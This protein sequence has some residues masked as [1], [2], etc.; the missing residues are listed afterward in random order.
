MSAE[1]GADASIKSL[2]RASGRAYGGRGQRRP[3][4]VRT[5]GA[6][7]TAVCTEEFDTVGSPKAERVTIEALLV[8]PQTR[9]LH[10]CRVRVSQD[11]IVLCR[12]AGPP[13][14][15]HD[16]RTRPMESEPVLVSWRSLRGFSA[17]ESYMTPAG[18]RLQVLE[19]DADEG[20][21]T[22]LAAAPEVSEL[23]GMVGR[24]SGHWRLAR[25]PLGLVLGGR[26][27]RASRQVA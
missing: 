21:L 2:S 17:D 1:R 23:F 16:E 15:Q 22:L 20:V 14:V 24:W 26:R 12:F 5:S 18:R 3:G 8:H 6:V 19:I 7:A 13:E 11:G 27:K 25:S 10:N 9:S 4:L